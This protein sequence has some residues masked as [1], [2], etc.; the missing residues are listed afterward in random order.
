MDVMPESFIHALDKEEVYVSTNT[1]C[2][3]GD[4]SKAIIALYNDQKRA[5]HTIRISLSSRTTTKEITKFLEIFDK[6]YN[7][8]KVLVK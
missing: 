4:I 2:S 1:A 5:K 8:L 3:S 7:S 6:C